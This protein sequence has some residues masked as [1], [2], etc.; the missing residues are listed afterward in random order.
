MV[1]DRIVKRIVCRAS[2]IGDTLDVLRAGG[3]RSEERVVL[4]LARSGAREPTEVVEVYE[5]DQV[6]EID[7]FKLPP[8]S[9]RALMSHLAKTRRRIVAQIHTHPGMAFHSEADDAWAIVQH[10]GALS[11]VLPRFALDTHPQNFLERAKVY[12]FSSTGEWELR[13]GFG[14][15]AAMEIVP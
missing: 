8:E 4:W 6:A 14:S 1:E 12:E 2:V 9:M 5:P 10:V 15:D 3:R 13:P 7:F 11:L